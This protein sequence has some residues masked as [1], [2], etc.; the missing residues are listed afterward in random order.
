MIARKPKVGDWA[1][2]KSRTLDPRQVEKVDDLGKNVKLRIGTVVS[3]WLPA[4]NYDFKT[5]RTDMRVTDTQLLE[6]W[7]VVKQEWKLQDEQTAAGKRRGEEI[8]AKLQ[9]LIKQSPVEGQYRDIE[10]RDYW[11]VEIPVTVA[12]WLLEQWDEAMS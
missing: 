10:Y 9:N 1:D 7:G 2:H 6:Q 8:V 5:K 4:K 3:A 11:K 12:E